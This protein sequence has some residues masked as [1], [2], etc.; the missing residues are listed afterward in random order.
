MLP[1]CCPRLLSRTAQRA[2]S[3]KLQFGDNGWDT[4]MGNGTAIEQSNLSGRHLLAALKAFRKGNFSVRLPIDLTGLD[5]EIADAFNDV[6]ELNERMSKA[7][8]KARSGTGPS[9]RTR[10]AC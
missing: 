2:W 8:S 9:C 5:G 4:S 10:P 3:A 1:R 6:V 7:V